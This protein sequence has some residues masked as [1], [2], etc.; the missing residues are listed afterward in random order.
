MYSVPPCV[1]RLR[2][3]THG[4]TEGPRRGI[5]FSL[6]VSARRGRAPSWRRQSPVSGNR[7]RLFR[8]KRAL[9]SLPFLPRL[10]ACGGQAEGKR[11]AVEGG[12]LFVDN[13]RE[14]PSGKPRASLPAKND[15]ANNKGQNG[16]PG[17]N[18]DDGY[19]EAR[20]IHHPTGRQG[21][22]AKEE[23]DIEERFQPESCR[24]LLIV[25]S[26]SRT[27]DLPLAG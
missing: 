11:A 14:T 8:N 27:A 2:R 5:Q 16:Q 25:P 13:Q 19:L 1:R 15:R 20:H 7:A 21:R 6:S 10:A 3:R 17:D 18:E 23:G 4:G 26:W 22:A 12:S 24:H 9:G